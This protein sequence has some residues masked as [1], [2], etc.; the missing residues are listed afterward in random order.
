MRGLCELAAQPVPLPLSC[1]LEEIVSAARGGLTPEQRRRVLAARTE[2]GAAILVD[3]PLLSACLRRLIENALEATDGLVLLVARRERE[4]A[5]FSVVDDAPGGLGPDWRLVPF[6]S[7]KPNHLG[8]GLTLTRRDVGLLNGRLEF[9]S[10]PG[11]G[12]CVRITVPIKEDD[13]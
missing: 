4:H 2:P 5:S 11:S 9:L 1:S 12:T 10:T 7:T 13:R 8:L 3:G 6:H